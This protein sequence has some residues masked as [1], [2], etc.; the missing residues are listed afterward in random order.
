MNT[1]DR[2]Q[3][4]L[5]ATAAAGTLGCRSLSAPQPL[6]IIDTHTHFYDPTRP[7]GVPW[8]PPTDQLLSRPTYPARY[9]EQAVRRPVTGTV[10]VEASDVVEDNQW[11]LDLAKDDPFI[12]GLSGN[13]PLGTPEFARHLK[14]FTRNPL[15]CGMRHRGRD[16]A[17][18]LE[19]ADFLRDVR[20]LADADKQLDVLGTTPILLLSDRLA[21]AVPSLR[22]I[23]DH[24]ANTK[25]DGQ[26]VDPIWERD[27]RAVA[28][29]PNVYMKVSGLV[30]GTGRRA[31]DAPADVEF[32]RPWLDIVWDAF[33]ED[34][35]IYGS[36]WP[37]SA[38]FAPLTTV[39]ALVHD[40]FS[41]KGERPLRKVFSENA[42]RFY[43]WRDRV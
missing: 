15:W 16:L 10:V 19:S 38:R 13:L 40:Y 1:M 27:I 2:R 20:L 11:I 8:P 5:T 30:E 14:R 18:D 7:G 25:I 43:H 6:V 33:G 37:V 24:L 42:R 32:Y 26:K 39:Q 35:L 34:R 12:V 9:R 29:R 3:F 17:K 21:K 31:G 36:N 23:V 4:L 28:R 22:I 41:A